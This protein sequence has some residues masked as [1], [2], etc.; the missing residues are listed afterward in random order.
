M[1]TQA[2]GL[3]DEVNENHR[4]ET[5]SGDDLLLLCSDGLFDELDEQEIWQIARQAE[6]P[7]QACEALI[8]AANQAGGSDN[9]AAVLVRLQPG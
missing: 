9:I 3:D 7:Q 1:L 4:Q 5:L 8:A 2:I 6:N